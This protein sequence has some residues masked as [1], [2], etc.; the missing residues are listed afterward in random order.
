VQVPGAGMAN[1]R[2][3]SGAENPKSPEN[4]RR[5][6]A[7]EKTRCGKVKER[8]SHI[9]WKALRVSRLSHS[10]GGYCLC[11]IVYTVNVGES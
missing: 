3:L 5:P 1:L 8:L 9:A 6:K 11:V 2:L 10:Y 7:V 4:R